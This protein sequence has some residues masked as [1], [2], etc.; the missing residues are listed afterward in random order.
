MGSAT[1]KEMTTEDYH[2]ILPYNTF[3]E[4]CFAMRDNYN[5]NK[6][7]GSNIESTAIKL[8]LEKSMKGIGDCK[9]YLD[10]GSH[11]L[12]LFVIK[13]KA[14]RAPA[15][16]LPWHNSGRRAFLIRFIL[17]RNGLVDHIEI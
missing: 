13:Y 17:D 10:K 14:N 11:I 12:S 16:Y 9:D 15:L 7:S 2:A 8:R 6:S 3:I 4:Q 1:Q 5:A